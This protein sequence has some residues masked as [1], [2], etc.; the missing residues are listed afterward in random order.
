MK[1]SQGS[2]I[3]NSESVVVPYGR[4]RNDWEVELGTVIGRTA[5]YVSANPAQDYVFGYMAT[6]DISDRGGGHQAAIRC[7]RTGLSEKAM[8]PL[9]L[10]AHGSSPRSFTA[11]RCKNSARA[12][13]S[14]K[15]KCRK[16]RLAT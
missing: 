4:N 8:A 5:K 15:R 2:V 11:T 9:L 7:A 6:M 16:P 13:K 3:G 1:P 12:S 10:R 14:A